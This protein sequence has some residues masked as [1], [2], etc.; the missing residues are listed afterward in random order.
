[1]LIIEN[2]GRQPSERSHGKRRLPMIAPS[3]PNIMSKD[4]VIVLLSIQMNQRKR[5]EEVKMM[6]KVVHC[7][8][9]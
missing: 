6:I 4:T 2:G 9:W 1:M 5:E 3:L 7:T 8:L